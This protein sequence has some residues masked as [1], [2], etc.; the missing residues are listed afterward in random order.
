MAEPDVYTQETCDE[1]NF[2]TFP[3]PAND[4][5]LLYSDERIYNIPDDLYLPISF[6][7]LAKDFA[8][9]SSYQD[10]EYSTL[11]DQIS[12]LFFKMAGVR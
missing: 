1:D 7:I 4:M 3:K 12:Q 11:C 8:H 2:I 5:K 6:K 10:L 9:P